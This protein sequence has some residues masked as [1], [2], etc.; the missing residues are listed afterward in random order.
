MGDHSGHG[1]SKA[2]QDRVTV[3]REL[4]KRDV[5]VNEDSLRRVGIMISE[6][7]SEGIGQ[8]GHWRWK[9]MEKGLPQQLNGVDCGVFVVMMIACMVRLSGMAL[10]NSRKHIAFLHHPVSCLRRT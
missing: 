2:W 4:A 6:T 8:H 5:G 3:R 9:G 1:S 7:V 10:V